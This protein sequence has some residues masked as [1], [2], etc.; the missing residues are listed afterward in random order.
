[1][2]IIHVCNVLSAGDDTV[3]GVVEFL[4]AGADCM[5]GLWKLQYPGDQSMTG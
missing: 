5:I 4:S 3:D 2:I 1:M